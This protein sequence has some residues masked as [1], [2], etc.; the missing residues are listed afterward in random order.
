MRCCAPAAGGEL[1]G[2]LVSGKTLGLVGFG[3]IG[4]GVAR[5]AMGFSMRVLAYDP[6]MEAAKANLAPEMA[7]VEF[8]SMEELLA[9]S[10]FVSAHAPMLPETR[11]MFNAA[12][13][14]Q[15]KPTAYFIN[16]ARGPLVDEDALLEALEKG[17][18]AGAALDVYSQE[19]LPPNH[20]M[21]QAP[22]TVLAP[23]NAFNAVETARAT[24]IQTVENLFKVWKGDRTAPVCNPAVWDAPALRVTK[25]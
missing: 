2:V 12:C 11:G 9:Q 1:R 22:N 21:R 5:R 3:Q 18:I 4:Q 13:F 23:H 24:S 6:P 20:R 25:A 8:V 7:P 15:M 19:P 17:T 16:T 14:A 10:D